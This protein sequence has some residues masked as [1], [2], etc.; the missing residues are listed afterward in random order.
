MW[1]SSSQLVQLMRA[2]LEIIANPGEAVLLKLSSAADPPSNLA[3]CQLT[4][5]IC[6]LRPGGAKAKKLFFGRS[7]FLK[8][9]HNIKYWSRAA[10]EEPGG[11]GAKRMTWKPPSPL[12]TSRWGANR[13]CGEYGSM[14]VRPL[15]TAKPPSLPQFLPLF[16]GPT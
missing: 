2:S 8:L 1:P 4:G 11:R 10:A 3:G 12:H 16:G 6:L 14:G 9:F 13:R 7:P 15:P 5:T